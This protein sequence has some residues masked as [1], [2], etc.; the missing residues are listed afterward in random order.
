MPRWVRLLLGLLLVATLVLAAAGAW[1]LLRVP[2]DQVPGLAA[3]DLQVEQQ[4]LGS[5][6]VG[7]LEV[8]LTDD[9]LTLRDTARDD[10]VVWASAPGRG[11]VLAIE[12]DVTWR[13]H[14]GYFWPSVTQRCVLAN[15]VVRSATDDAGRLE[16]AGLVQ[17]CDQ[18]REFLLTIEPGVAAGDAALEVS[19]R[20]VDAVALVTGRS[21]G[22]GV[23]GFGEQF[24]AFA[25]GPHSPDRRARAGGRARCPAPHRARER[26]VDRRRWHAGNDLC[27]VAVVRH[28]RRTRRRPRP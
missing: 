2:R 25:L 11:F 27:S 5:W 28:R 19:V 17:G 1:L 20:D 22:A 14:R 13:E 21:P 23:H 6:R 8:S 12:G 24:A 15:Q 10:L 4:A 16:I 18:S 3:G 9:G 26:H 7:P